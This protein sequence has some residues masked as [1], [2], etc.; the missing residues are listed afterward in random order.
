MMFPDHEGGRESRP[1]VEEFLFGLFLLGVAILV[2][3]S[4]RKLSMGTAGDMGPG[5]FPRAI[6]W[7]MALFGLFFV[8]KSFVTPG[9]KVPAPHWRGLILV[10]A[11]VGIFALLVNTAGLALASFLAM[12]TISLA[13]KETRLIEVL[14]FSALLSAASVLLFVKALSLPV[15][16]FSW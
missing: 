14:I 3:V 13:S 5:Y 10:P 1:A 6:A 16:I 9:E 12:I 4:I 7:G 15:P 11:A 2:L 8:G